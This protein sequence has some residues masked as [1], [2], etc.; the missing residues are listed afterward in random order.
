VSSA[1]LEGISARLPRYYAESLESWR[2]LALRHPDG[3]VDLSLGSPVDEVPALA[4]E[5]LLGGAG[6]SGY[7]LTIGS[8]TLREAAVDWLRR[9]AGAEL[10]TTDQVLPVIG[11]K[12]FV[13]SA[14]LHLGLG[15]GDVVAVPDLA[16]PTYEVGAALAGCGV[17]RYGSAEELADASLVWLNSPS[18]PDGRVWS[19]EEMAAVV[20]WARRRGAVVISDECYLEFGWDQQPVSVLSPAVNG[21]SLDGVLALHSESKRS[22]LAGYRSGLVSGDGRL[23]SALRDVRRNIGLIMPAPVQAATTALLADDAHVAEQRERYARRRARLLPALAAAGFTVGRSQG[24]LYL[25]VTNGGTSEEALQALA[26]RGIL[27]VSGESY[28]PAGRG[29]V[30]LALTATD[31]DVERASARLEGAPR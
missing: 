19:S 16:Y 13:G 21:G 10:V 5:A 31:E 6:F 14:A 27:A 4:R 15:P 23:V 18:N 24:G 9:T 1:R 3:L 12:E 20:D 26:E 28:G 17:E 11:A 25:W 22:N 2:V 8:P 7:P 29:Y 30:R